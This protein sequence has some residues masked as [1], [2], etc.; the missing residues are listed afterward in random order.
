MKNKNWF[1]VSK[2]GLRQLWAG[3]SKDFI[4]RELV[5]NAWDENISKCS[6][7]SEWRNGIAYLVMEDDSP[8]GFKDITHAFTLFAPT[9][10]RLIP[11]K[12]GRFNVG[13]KQILAMCKEA[14]VSTTKGTISFSPQGRVHKRLKREKG[15]IISLTLRMKEDDF[16]EMLESVDLY[17]P[18]KGIDFRVND[19]PVLYKEPYKVVEVSLP[20]EIRNADGM[21]KAYRK[22]KANIHNAAGSEAY[23]YE[24]GLP[25]CKIDCLYHVDVQQKVPMSI[26]R[27]KVTQSYLRKIFTLVL[28]E[29]YELVPNVNVS[30]GWVREAMSNKDISNEAVKAVV[31]T[32][33]GDKVVV[34]NPTD[35]RSV[36][37][38]LSHGYK[39]IYGNELSRSE[40]MNIR[41]TGAIRS[42]STLFPTKFT[43]DCEEVEKDENMIKVEELTK[44]IAKRCLG[45]D[46]NVHFLKWTGVAAQYGHKTLD[47]NVKKLG[48]RFFDPPINNRV[49][50]LILHELAHE[51]GFHVEASYQNCLSRMAGELIM[52]ALEEPEFFKLGGKK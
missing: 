41:K 23:L 8:E 3:K 33:Y 34:A 49:I 16:K 22:T 15:S 25:V 28:N 48:R 13:E 11:E 44:K 7:T 37:E 43:D 30:D 4:I 36:D 10:K 40:W 38:A 51:K 27:N 12:R 39:V 50:D 5:Q 14:V 52:L 42:S 18:P 32:R 47:F 19:N 1:E 26:D 6:F 35:R 24:M 46:I 45:I 2:E 17:L 9:Y 20:T 21:V 31:K 29:T